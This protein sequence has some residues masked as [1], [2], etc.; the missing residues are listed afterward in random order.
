MRQLSPAKFF[1]TSVHPTVN[2]ARNHKAVVLK[3]LI[4]WYYVY[5]IFQ[6]FVYITD[7]LVTPLSIFAFYKGILFCIVL[8]IEKAKLTCK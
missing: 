6:S 5:N 1:V 3:G 7:D 2:K 8:I 4:E